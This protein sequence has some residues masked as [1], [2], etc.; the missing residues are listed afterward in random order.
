MQAAVVQVFFSFLVCN[1]RT[2]LY[3]NRC[4]MVK[5]TGGVYFVAIL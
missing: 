5:G 4:I 2:K 3:T 1:S